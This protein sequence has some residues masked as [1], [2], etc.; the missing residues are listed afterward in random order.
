M[1]VLTADQVRAWDQYSMRST[2][3]AP[4]E[5]MEKA[6]LAC[7]TWLQT[8]RY[9]E[10]PFTIF[11]GKGNNGGDGLALARM[12]SGQGLEVTACILE[13]GHKGTEEFQSNLARL[14]ETAAS[15]R[16][17]SQEENWHPIPGNQIVI[18]ALFGTGL[19]RP[20]QNL[21]A[22]VVDQIN[23]AGLPIISIDMP[24]GLFSDQS[25]M[26][27]TIV[28][29]RHTLSFE[30]YKTGLLLPENA[31]YFGEVSILPIGLHPGY[32]RE[33]R[34]FASMID[35]QLAH[36]IVKKRQPYTHKGNFGHAAL[37][38]GSYGMM[39][40]A[41]LAARGCLRSGVG[42]LTMHIPTCGY[43][44]LQQSVPEAMC[45]V[46]SG[47]AA[48]ESLSLAEG[49]AAVGIGPGWG[50]HHQYNALLRASLP[51][52]NKPVV[53]DADGLNTLA[54]DPSLMELLPAA[55][56]VIT[57]HPGEWSRLAPGAANDFDRL[58]Q[59][60]AKAR[61]WQVHIILKG[62]HSWIIA[63]SGHKWVN[64]TGNAGMATGGTGDV[65]TGLLTGLL[66]QGYVPAEAACL[67]VYLHGRAGDLAETALSQEALLASDLPDYFGQA[68]RELHELS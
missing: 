60:A 25:S 8:S 16:F 45:Q 68:F 10:G 59:L 2:P 55:G 57:P 37:V 42:K 11:C 43:T 41:V 39:G 66:A 9:K 50:R 65:L 36:G 30:C 61:E 38:A 35:R 47:D 27:N 18:D 34:P 4:V 46:E 54:A 44:I 20:L 13:F 48:I 6:A 17:L 23:A 51:L 21:A 7:Y 49:Y 31:P 40:A 24:S 1:I 15:I 33:L 62:Q 67:A 22:F 12:L 29:A 14:H 3:I 5:L 28:R 53:I 26:G 32:L 58:Y 19:S 64:T 52:I 56:A 63:P